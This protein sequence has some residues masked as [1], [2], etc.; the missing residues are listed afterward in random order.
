MKLL[1][2]NLWLSAR[3]TVP[4]PL[5]CNLSQKMLDK[6]MMCFP[7]WFSQ[8]LKGVMLKS[9]IHVQNV[10]SE[11]YF[12]TLHRV[13]EKFSM[14]YTLANRT[15]VCPYHQK[16]SR[17]RTGNVYG[18]WEEQQSQRRV[19]EWDDW[20]ICRVHVLFGNLREGTDWTFSLFFLAEVPSVTPYQQLAAKHPT[21]SLQQA[22]MLYE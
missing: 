21:N 6:A 7:G 9:Y 5:L 11:I 13:A 17:Q 12:W 8:F 15:P 14:R 3:L 19:F 18:G 10:S 4:S 22:R 20:S 1:N 16:S 2:V